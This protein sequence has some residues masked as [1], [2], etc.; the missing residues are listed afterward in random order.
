MKNVL[1]VLTFVLMSS[2]AFASSGEKAETNS[3]ADVK[4]ENVVEVV[5]LA[6]LENSSAGEA[7]DHFFE[8]CTV[9]VNLTISDGAGNTYRIEGSFTIVGKSCVQV[10]KEAMSK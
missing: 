9:K 7:D 4:I 6:K 3:A 1:V 2:L 8:D 10:L 5:E